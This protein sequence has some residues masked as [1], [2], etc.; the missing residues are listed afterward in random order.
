[1]SYAVSRVSPSNKR[2]MQRIEALLRQEGITLDRSSPAAW[3]SAT[4]TPCCRTC[5]R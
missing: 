1:M 5:P 3:P 2:A 4:G